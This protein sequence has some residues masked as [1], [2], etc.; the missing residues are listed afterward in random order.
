MK[1]ALVGLGTFTAITIA[2]LSGS[3]PAA[4]ASCIQGTAGCAVQASVNGDGSGMTHDS[5]DPG[6]THD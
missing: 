5:T 4:A 6:M 2:A 3:T 1:R